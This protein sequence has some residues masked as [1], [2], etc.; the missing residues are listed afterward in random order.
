MNKII[1]TLRTGHRG[2]DVEACKRAVYRYLDDGDAWAKL[3]KAS[4]LSRRTFGVF[5]RTHVNRAHKKAGLAQSGVIGPRLETVMRG[6]GAFDRRA[7]S[8]LAEYAMEKL[9]APYQGFA[10]LDRSLW[11]PYSLGRNWGLGDGPGLASGTY[12]PAATLPGGGKSDHAVY[13]S[14]AFDLDIGPDTGWRNLRAREVF[15]VLKDHPAVE[16]VILGNRIAIDGQVREYT[17]GAHENHLHASG[18]R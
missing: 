17:A 11:G 13:P 4:T 1:R 2:K 12:N 5:F 14:M 9:V 6:A 15:N 8:L 7:D 18:V 10:S 16:Y 3:A